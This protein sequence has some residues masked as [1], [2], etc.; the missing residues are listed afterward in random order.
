MRCTRIAA[1]AVL[2][3]AF[4]LVSLP[5]LHPELRTHAAGPPGVT[6]YAADA[7]GWAHDPDCALCRVTSQVRSA[8][9][10][11]AQGI[12]PAAP[13]ASLDLHRAAEL[14]PGAPDPSGP[15]AR[16]PPLT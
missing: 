5:G 13:R 6:A 9:H 8:L 10:G 12:T 11:P 2:I 16:A 15:L 14:S 1:R 7:D 4:G 3:L